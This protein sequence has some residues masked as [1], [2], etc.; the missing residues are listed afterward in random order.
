MF[1]DCTK[2]TDCS[3]PTN[4]YI[5]PS[6]LR[7]FDDVQYWVIGGRTGQRAN[8]DVRENRGVPMK[9]VQVSAAGGDLEVVDR[10]VPIPDPDQVRIEVEACGVCHG[11]EMAKTGALPG[12]S[13]PQIPGHEVAGRIDVVGND[14]TEWQEGD[15]VTV[16]WHAGH[17]F[18][19]D[20]CR[21][22]DFFNCEN[23]TDVTGITRNG[24]Y[25]EYMVASHEA[26][27][28]IPKGLDAVSAGPLVCAGLTA[29]N[30]L[31]HADGEPGDLVA[32]QGVGG[33]GHM[34]IQFAHAAGFETVAL[35]RGTDKENLAFDLGADHF[36]DTN[37]QDPANELQELGGAQ[38]ILGT[39]PSI[40]ALESA[41]GGLAYSGQ[42]FSLAV[43]DDPLPTPVEQLVPNRQS[44]N[45]W[46]SGHARDA[47]DTLEFS[48]RRDIEPLVE[49]YPLEEADEAYDRMMSGEARF[50]AVLQPGE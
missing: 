8:P 17:C 3:F 1:T 39:A 34:G 48:A 27:A 9:A 18:V 50:R 40:G 20:A 2:S 4:T 24:G 36:I 33:V 5:P 49:T 7:Y 45:G 13:Y 37:S 11:D 38:V 31:R 29:Y 28:R 22:G 25:A 35:S 23:E 32:V 42:L 15:R 30:A 19:C 43:P 44:V 16:G 46:S 21:H 6:P 47:Q 10:D 12:T 41:L 26:L 14:V